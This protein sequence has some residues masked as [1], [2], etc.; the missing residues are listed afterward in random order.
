MQSRITESTRAFKIAL[1]DRRLSQRD[2]A[3]CA[4]ID[5]T[6]LHR[7]VYGRS[8]PTPKERENLARILAVPEAQLFPAGGGGT[9]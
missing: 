2:L 6:R 4:H 5:Y 3:Q 1:L 7:I 8:A 9:P